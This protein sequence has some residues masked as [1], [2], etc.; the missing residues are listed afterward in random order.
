MASDL[1]FEL[2]L[3]RIQIP[4]PRGAVRSV[5]IPLGSRAAVVI[6]E[7]A[8]TS[9]E[10]QANITL[11]LEDLIR[12]HGFKLVLAEGGSG[13]LN[14]NILPGSTIRLSSFPDVEVRRRIADRHLDQGRLGAVQYLDIIT[15]FEADGLRYEIVGV[16]DAPTHADQTA[17]SHASA[18]AWQALKDT[19]TRFR[20]RLSA[21]CEEYLSND[22]VDYYRL[23][24]EYNTDQRKPT[25]YLEWLAIYAAGDIGP[26]LADVLEVQRIQRS[27][28]MFEAHREYSEYLE[29]RETEDEAGWS[30]DD[31]GLRSFLD[32]A[33]EG[34]KESEVPDK[35]PNLKQFARLRER[36]AALTPMWVMEQLFAEIAIAHRAVLGRLGE[37]TSL[38]HSF[39]TLILLLD[40]IS[41]ALQ[42]TLQPETVREFFAED[43]REAFEATFTDFVQLL[44]QAGRDPELEPPTID[45]QALE[46][47]ARFYR[48]AMDRSEIFSSKVAEEMRRTGNDRAIL[49]VGGFHSRVI[50]DNLRERFSF[51]TQRICPRITKAPEP[52]WRTLVG[53]PSA[54]LTAQDLF[55]DMTREYRLR[56][57]D[58]DPWCIKLEQYYRDRFAVDREGREEVVSLIRRIGDS[59]DF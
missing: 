8:P 17:A 26:Q 39:V 14:L 51:A 38:D 48:L 59:G 3:R 45:W 18:Q 36:T 12:R 7:D 49:I 44:G 20:H 54:P 47:P 31:F 37:G 33:M 58:P 1:H 13:P 19:L 27:V 50:S 42:L 25:D 32:H 10:A 55:G 40:Q 28:N 43:L 34:L 57:E 23:W 15:D 22:L 24:Q 5:D 2:L 52:F 6:L 30:D 9:R 4:E 16:E 11:I 29:E 41:D 56:I 35:Y 21:A 53:G 46:A